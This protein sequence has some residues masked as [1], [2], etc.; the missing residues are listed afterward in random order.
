[1][2]PD[3]PERVYLLEIP[4]RSLDIGEYLTWRTRRD[5]SE[6]EALIRDMIPQFGHAQASSHP[7]GSR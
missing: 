2:Y 6:A 7:S 5:A 4:A 3:P 1:M